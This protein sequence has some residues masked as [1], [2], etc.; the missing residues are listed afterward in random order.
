MSILT[1][2]KDIMAS[3]INA[4]LDK[5]EDP[6]KMV[7][8]YLRNLNNDLGKV[9]AETASIMAEEQRARRALDDAVAE[10]A[11]MQKYAVKA[12]EAGNEDDARKFLEKKSALTAKEAE[13]QQSYE[14]ATANAQQ[15]RQMHDKLVA[16]IGELESRRAVI[17]GKAAVAKTRQRMNK[18]GESVAGSNASINAFT[19]MEEKVNKSLDE[20]NAMAELNSGPKDD[21]KDL[22]AKYDTTSDV[23]DELAELKKQLNLS[24]E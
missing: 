21:I 6:G 1:R 24:D 22:T 2:F 14:L 12:L 15:M 16:D 19:R 4:L 13:L 11:K 17:K 3:N 8:Q 10:V 9:K 5:A 7:D 18:V 20:A 23:D